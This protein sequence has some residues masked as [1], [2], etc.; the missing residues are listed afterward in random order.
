MAAPTRAMIESYH[1]LPTYIVKVYDDV[2][3]V[4]DI[5]PANEILSIGGVNETVNNR[6]NALSFGDAVITQAT[7]TTIDTVT[8]P[9]NWKRAAV[10]IYL[11]F[12]TGDPVYAF[13]GYIVKRKRSGNTIQF[14]CEGILQVKVAEVKLHTRLYY[15]KPIATLTTATSI[16]NPIDGNYTAGLINE[17]FWQSGG[18]PLAQSGTYPGNQWYYECD[19]ALLTPEWSWIAGENL[20]DELYRLARAAGG[21]IYQTNRNVVKYV[22]PFKFNLG[23]TFVIRDS[24]YGTFEESESTLQFVGSVRVSYTPRA[25]EPEQAVY[26][27]TESRVIAPLANIQLE[28][29]P[30]QPI[31]EWQAHLEAGYA[32]GGTI[33]HSGII[34]AYDP[35]NQPITPNLAVNDLDAQRIKFTITNPVNRPIVVTKIEFAGQPLAAGEQQTVVHNIGNNPEITTEDNPYIQSKPYA[36][37]VA[38]M[39]YDFHSTT[40]PIISLGDCIYDPDRYVGETVTFI[41]SYY[42]MSGLYRIVSLSHDLTGVKTQLDLVDITGVVTQDQVFIVGTAYSAGDVRKVSY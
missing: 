14:T 17:I 30:Q 12:D 34:T 15:R 39:V 27:D 31:Y 24:Y 38:K 20:V 33:T 7:F 36:E 42:S 1:P 23:S 4:F 21:Q 8:I 18:R 6:E 3:T 28:G 22:Q 41:S 11:S 13:Y 26:T 40:K 9:T 35:M 19:N 32:V 37:Q 2:A 5:I 29:S 25:L 10:Y 16:E